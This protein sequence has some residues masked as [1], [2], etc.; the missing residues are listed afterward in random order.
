M[1]VSHLDRARICLAQLRH[2]DLDTDDKKAHALAA[3]FEAV[4]R[5][6]IERPMGAVPLGPINPAVENLTMSDDATRDAAIRA[7]CARHV[8]NIQYCIYPRCSTPKQVCRLAAIVIE[9]LAAYQAARAKAAARD[10]ATSQ[11]LKPGAL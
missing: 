2:H 1:P 8:G 6:T 9:A 3:E 7:A 10:E 4:A 11:E 5:A